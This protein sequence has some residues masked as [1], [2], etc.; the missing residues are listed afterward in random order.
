[1]TSAVIVS[2]ARTPLAKSWKGA[3]NMT[4]GATLGGHAVQHAVQR[5]GIDP[6]S[7]DDVIMGCAT[8]EG[9]TG[10]N[11]ARQ[12]ALRAGLPITTSGMTINRFCS[13]G[14]QTIATAA[15]RIIAG[16]GEVYVAGGVESISCVQNEANK[17]MLADPWLVKHK[18][19]IYWNMLQ[20]A[21]QVAKRYNI[22]RD[23]MDEYGAQSQQRA[24]AA[25]EAGLFKAEIAPITVLAGVADPVMGLR[26]KEVT[27]ENDE[28]I[29]PGTTKEGISGIRPAIPGGVISAG[30]ASQFSDGGGACV[31]VD[32]KYAEQKGLKPL[33]RFLGFAVAGCEPDEMGIGPVFAIPKVLKRLGL[34][35]NDIDLWE[36]N[37]AFAVQVIYCRDKLGIPGDR[38]NVNGGAI[39]VGHPYGVSGQRLTG[40]ALIEGKRRGAKKVVV[41][42]CIGGGMGAAGVFE[43]L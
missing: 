30:N 32:E 7:V 39:A 3:F 14:L 19:E 8:P 25:L 28:G 22:G 33:G 1:M 2:T 24:T 11:I 38:L 15:Q 36:L 13:S 20:T 42:M 5:A 29:R 43:V 31:V 17:H 23:A 21:E 6:A 27:V 10:S 37:E 12:I 4:H 40:H 9:A 18:P 26:T 34:T 41:T 16:E 35:V